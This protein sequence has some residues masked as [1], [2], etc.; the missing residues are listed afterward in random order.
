MPSE[1]ER[2]IGAHPSSPHFYG[3]W[4]NSVDISIP[5]TDPNKKHRK[6]LEVKGKR[7]AAIRQIAE[8]LIQHH[9]DGDKILELQIR[10]DEILKKY[11]LKSMSKYIDEQHFFPIDPS[12]KSGNL[13]EIILSSYLQQSSGLSLLAY[14]LTYNGNVDSALKGDDCLLFDKGNLN[15]KIIV[16]EA[17]FRGKPTPKAV[18]DIIA[19]LEGAKRLPISLTFISQHFTTKGDYVMSGKISDLQFEMKNGKIPII[20]VG[21]LLSTKSSLLSEDTVKQVENQ[22]ST[23]NPNLVMLSLGIDDPQDIVDKAF[24]LARKKLNKE[25]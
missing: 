4:L 17:K 22:L 25:I 9:V 6:L 18:K 11:K 15:N 1:Q 12:T 7:S 16:G 23:T 24:E 20:N 13:T 21:L 19:N 14:K 8:Y 5:A 10:K 3:I 2:L